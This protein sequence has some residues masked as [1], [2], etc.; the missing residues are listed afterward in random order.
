MTLSEGGNLSHTKVGSQWGAGGALVVRKAVD[1]ARFSENS[2]GSAS[3][4]KAE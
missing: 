4:A 2:T 1:P 3:Y